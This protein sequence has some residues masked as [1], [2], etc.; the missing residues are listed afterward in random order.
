MIVI[1]AGHGGSDPGAVSAFREKDKTLQISNYQFERFKELG[2]P[3]KMSRYIDETLTPDERI[4]RIMEAYG[5]DPNIIVLSNHINAGGGQGAE[6][7]YALRNND[8]LSKK[9][10]TEIQNTG[11]NIRAIYQRKSNVNPNNDYYFIHRRTGENETVLVEYGFVDNAKDAELLKENW[12]PLAEAVIKGIF[13]YK[14]YKYIPP[15]G[16]GATFKYTVK[17]GDS[18]YKIANMYKTSVDALMKLNNLT[19]DFLPIGKV[20]QIP[21]GEASG[22]L[23]QTYIVKVGDNLSTIAYNY[24][25]TVEEIMKTN[26]LTTDLLQIGQILQIPTGEKQYFMYTVKPGDSL[27][28][29]A[30]RFKTSINAIKLLNG[31]TTDLIQI[32]QVLKVPQAK[33]TY[34]VKVG[35][36]LSTIAYNYGTTVEKIKIENNLISDVIYPGMELKI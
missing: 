13:D 19:S 1:D 3:V 23:T 8:V 10:A 32:G 4:K 20:L 31:L 18:L 15:T 12:K 28:S 17:Y 16:E 5:N 7:I 30:I 33:T 34:I 35:D 21:T 36:N 25:T 27:Y 6:V 29:I 11:Q 24:G 14:G 26:G 22:E 2:I 9:I